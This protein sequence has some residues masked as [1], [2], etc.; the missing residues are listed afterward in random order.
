MVTDLGDWLRRRLKKGIE[1]QGSA[2]QEVLNQCE[3]G[4]VEL[5]KEWSDQRSAQLSIRACTSL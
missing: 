4:T 2:A 1:E 5:C 3:L